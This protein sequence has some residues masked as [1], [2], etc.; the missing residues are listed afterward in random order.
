[1]TYELLDHVADVKFRAEGD[2]L[3]AALESAVEA[4]ADITGGDGLEATDTRV[5]DAEA[6][7]LDALFFDFLDRLIYVQDAEGVAVVEPL[8]VTLHE[9]G[10]G[11]AVRASL[12]VAQIEAD[13]ALLDIKAPTYSEMVVEERD[14]SWRLDAVLDI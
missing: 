5:V 4:F 13:T 7:N 6:E 14:G 12:E 9:A 10:D 1:M 2:T 8:E 11:L 3:A